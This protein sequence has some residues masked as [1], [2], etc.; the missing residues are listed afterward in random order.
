MGV[1][2]WAAVAELADCA[3]WGEA[4]KKR[5]QLTGA[6]A[7]EYVMGCFC[8]AQQRRGLLACIEE[9]VAQQARQRDVLE[10]AKGGARKR[11]DGFGQGF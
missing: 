4:E 2:S 5:E 11:F 6:L 10:S 7:G 1:G 8:V 9:G 3:R